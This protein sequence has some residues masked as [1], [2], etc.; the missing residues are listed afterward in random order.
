MA[1]YFDPPSTV[2]ARLVRAIH[3]NSRWNLL[4][5]VFGVAA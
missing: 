2:I 4:P 1:T 5:V 3:E